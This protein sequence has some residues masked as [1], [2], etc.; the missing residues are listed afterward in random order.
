M[1]LTF[2]PYTLG[3]KHQF[4]LA[5]S[6]RGTTPVMLTKIEHKGFT[7]YG[8]ASMPPYL[9]ESHDSVSKFLKMLDLRKFN[10]PFNLTEILNYINNIVPGNTAAKAS[11]DIAMHDLLGKMIKQPWYKIWGFDKTKTPLTTYTIGIDTDEI[12]RQKVKEAEPYKILKVKLGRDNDKEIIDIV[13]SVT[14]KPIAVDI[15]Q[16][17]KDWKMALEMVYWL[18]EKNTLFVEQPMPKNQ[19][20]DMARLTEKSPLP[21]FADEAVQGIDDVVKIKGIYSGIN[22]KL[23]KCGGMR[24]AREMISIARAL[25]MQIMLGCMTETSCAISAAAQLAPTVDFADLDGNLL[26]NNDPFIGLKVTDGYTKPIDSHGI[27]V[28]LLNPAFFG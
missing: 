3:L 2:K 28:E 13:R 11:V 20:D 26:I 16:G 8:E 9:G 10:D 14:D 27:G 18:K 1:N 12:I 15:N 7:G 24:N 21:T 19:I 5:G 6:S 23:M 25:D 17:W 4:T 22:I